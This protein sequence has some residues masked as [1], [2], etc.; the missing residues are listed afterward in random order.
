MRQI[1]VNEWLQYLRGRQR[2]RNQQ[3][4]SVEPGSCTHAAA[5]HIDLVAA[6]SVLDPVPRTCVVLFYHEGLTHEQIAAA[7]QL[8]LGTVKSHITRSTVR[9]REVLSA[10][11]PSAARARS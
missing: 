9:L 6:L 1:A 3:P 5:E 4:P 10:Y 7:M 8:P 11:A 2:M